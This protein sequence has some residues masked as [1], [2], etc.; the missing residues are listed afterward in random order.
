MKTITMFIITIFK[1]SRKVEINRNY[2]SKCVENFLCIKRLFPDIAKF[3]DFRQKIL[4]SAELKSCVTWFIYFLDLLWV[5]Y[6]CA[7]FHYCRICVTN[8]LDGGPFC[9]HHPW[10]AS[11]K[12]ILNRVKG[13]LTLLLDATK[14]YLGFNRPSSSL[15]LSSFI[16]WKSCN[17]YISL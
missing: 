11:K 7:K 15:W 2:V 9:P 12:P 8:F 1:G 14:M 5:R 10:A 13:Y 17:I 6:N 4:M 3:A 16:I